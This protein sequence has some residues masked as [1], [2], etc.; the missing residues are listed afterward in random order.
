MASEMRGMLSWI[1]LPSEYIATY[2]KESTRRIRKS[3]ILKYLRLYLGPGVT[4]IDAGMREYL[5][6]RDSAAVARDL[7]QY[8]VHPDIDALAPMS[9]ASYLSS[10]EC[11]LQ[12]ACE[13]QLPPLQRKLR[14]RSKREKTVAVVQELCP[15]REIWQA[16][17]SHLGTRHRAE[18]L[19]C[20]SGG[21]RIGEVLSLWMSD[22]FL[23]E[24]P[25]RIELRGAATKNGLPR[26][27][28]VSREAADAL[29]AYLRVRDVEVAKGLAKCQNCNIRHDLREIFPMNYRNENRFFWSAIDAAGYGQRDVRTGRRVLHV[30]SARKWFITQAK[31]S[32]HPD[33]VESWVGHA[34]YL[35]SSYHRPSLDE[36]REEY[37]KCELDVTVSLP[38]DYYK[39]K[40][41]YES[42]LRKM[43]DAQDADREALAALRQELAELKARAVVPQNLPEQPL[44]PDFE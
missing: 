43:R 23:D 2:S 14:E 38:P 29:R 11:Y 6:S 33:Y 30:H 1:M 20:L 21:L 27:T 32:A 31:R 35:S 17:L 26:R 4:D 15:T 10:I 25:C 18:L 13:F 19:L 40:S 12:D 34:G 3:G 24:T 44:I 36:E 8:Y 39:V 16:V 37:L 22:V 28:F 5:S 7:A 9:R 42:E 41:S